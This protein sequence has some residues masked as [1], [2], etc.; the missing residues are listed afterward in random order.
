MVI[1]EI[2]KSELL[3]LKEK[4]IFHGSS[5]LF[6]EC[7]PHQA[8]C[9]T[10]N[11]LNKQNAVYGTSDLRF[12]ILFCFEKLPV[13]KFDWAVVS[14]NGVRVGELYDGT[15]IEENSYGY[16]YCFNKNDFAICENKGVQYVCE[17][18]VIPKKV[19]KVFYKD[20]KD[21]FKKKKRCLK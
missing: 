7:L 4:Y 3:K 16:L 10:D 13:D 19:Y 14:Y 18:S 20:Y 15:Y 5:K 9:S 8:T 2:S 12:A 11:S 1:E 6:D 21:L 17:H